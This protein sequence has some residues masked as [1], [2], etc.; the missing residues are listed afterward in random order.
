MPG[1]VAHP[2]EVGAHPHRGDDD[3]QVGGDRLL[4]GEQVDGQRVELSRMRVELL[5]GLDDRLGQ[6]DVG[7]EQGGRG[8]G[9]GRAGQPGHLDELVGDGVEVLVERVAHGPLVLCRG[10]R[11]GA[12]TGRRR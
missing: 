4:A 6:V 9:H 2:L 1:E 12:E 3:A 11:Y 10:G 8:P 7:V 5:V